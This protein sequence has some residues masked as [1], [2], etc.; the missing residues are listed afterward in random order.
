MRKV[1][2]WWPLLLLLLFH[3]NGNVDQKKCLRFSQRKGKSEKMTENFEVGVRVLVF[4]FLIL[5]PIH[6]V[7]D[8]E[9]RWTSY[10]MV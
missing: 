2:I 3:C 4:L 5:G 7:V 1:V 8:L 10:H 9:S 6:H